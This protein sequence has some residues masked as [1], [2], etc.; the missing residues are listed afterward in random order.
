MIHANPNEF[1]KNE[2]E[3]NIRLKGLFCGFGE[4]K[5]PSSKHNFLTDM[6]EVR[7]DNPVA[8]GP[9]PFAKGNGQTRWKG[10]LLS[11]IF[12]SFFTID[13]VYGAPMFVNHSHPVGSVRSRNTIIDPTHQTHLKLA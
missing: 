6:H 4:L 9:H 8:K 5:T 2:K 3:K 12:L 13:P 11:T 1:A 7:D 10:P